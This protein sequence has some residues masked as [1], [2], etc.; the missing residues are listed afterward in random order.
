MRNFFSGD[1]GKF[2]DIGPA[3]LPPCNNI[4]RNYFQKVQIFYF[5]INSR[6]D[7]FFC[8]SVGIEAQFLFLLSANNFLRKQLKKSDMNEHLLESGI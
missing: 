6:C 5:Q 3:L 1:M 2:S 7:P 4:L 8:V